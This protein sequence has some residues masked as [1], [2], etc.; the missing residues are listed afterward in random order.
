[1]ILRLQIATMGSLLGISDLVHLVSCFELRRSLSRLIHCGGSSCTM[2]LGGIALLDCVCCCVDGGFLH[3]SYCPH[4]H[5]LGVVV[6]GVCLMMSYR[7]F[8]L[9][10]GFLMLHVVGHHHLVP[11]HHHPH[12]GSFGNVGSWLSGCIC[13]LKRM[14]LGFPSCLM[15]ESQHLGLGIQRPILKVGLGFVGMELGLRLV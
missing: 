9:H 12:L 14:G 1:M 3:C 2:T 8:L 13:L 15:I 6:G 10:G 5:H 11:M 4:H 7:V